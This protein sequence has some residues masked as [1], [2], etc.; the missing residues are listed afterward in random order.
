MQWARLHATGNNIKFL[1]S[2]AMDPPELLTDQGPR[3]SKRAGRS[4]LAKFRPHH[5]T[6]LMHELEM[7]LR[8]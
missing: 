4:F 2:L 1:L 5:I 8:W 7:Y 6:H 3:E